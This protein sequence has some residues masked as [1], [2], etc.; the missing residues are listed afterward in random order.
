MIVEEKTTSEINHEAMKVLYDHI[1]V[2]NTIRFI[3]QFSRGHGDYTKDREKLF[4]GKTRQD[5]IK[6]IKNTK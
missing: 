2:T 6:G 5:L 3:N 4:A 1:G